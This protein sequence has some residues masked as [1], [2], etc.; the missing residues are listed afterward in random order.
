L[1]RRAAKTISD[2]GYQTKFWVKFF[3]PKPISAITRESLLAFLAKREKGAIGKAKSPSP[4]LLNL[5]LTLFRSFFRWSR[6]Q[7][8]AEF[9][10]TQGFEKWKESR[11]EPRVLSPE[12]VTRLLRAC[13]EPYGVVVKREGYRPYQGERIFKPPAALYPACL[14]GLTSLLRKANVLQ[15]LWSELE[16]E[17]ELIRIPPK[18]VKTRTELVLPLSRTFRA[19]L[20]DLPVGGPQDFVFGGQREIKR[21]FRGALRRARIQNASFH[22]LRRT[23]ATYLLQARVPREIVERL[24]GWR[25]TGG[26]MLEHYRRVDVE[27][28]RKAVALLDRLVNGEGAVEKAQANV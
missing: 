14:L 12:E 23:G 28:L 22:T 13:R 2:Y 20:Q 10:P 26:V 1:K 9:D 7:G 16:L 18:R 6:R 4:K 27:E 19:S 15:L 17:N 3:G 21:A 25:S 5:N 11:R 8:Y 24:G